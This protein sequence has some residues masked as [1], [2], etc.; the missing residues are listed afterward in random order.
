MDSFVHTRFNAEDRSYLSSLKKEIHILSVSAGFAGSVL[1]E[2]DIIVSE[3][4]TNLTKH[5]INGEI[6]FRILGQN[7]PT[8]I[9]LI[10]IDGGPGFENAEKIFSDGY[11]TMNSLGQGLGAI[12]RLSDFVSV[13]SLPGWGTIVLCRIYLSRQNH[14]H[15]KNIPQ[16]CSIIVPK[17]GE[18]FCGDGLYIKQNGDEW[19]IFAGDG[20]GHGA[21]AHYAVSLAIEYFKKTNPDNLTQFIRG[22]DQALKKTRGLVGTIVT[23]NCEEK[24]LKLLGVGNISSKMFGSNS[25]T[26]LSYNGIIGGNIPN[27]MSE[28]TIS[29]ESN[30]LLIVCSDGIKTNY[31]NQRYPRI[32]KYDLSILAAAIYKDYSRK[33]DDTMIVI[34]RI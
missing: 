5:A 17:P 24:I 10:S 8:G 7:Q 9:E 6:L 28:Q 18:I 20:L 21:E 1:A 15:T 3:L 12:K 34:I 13:Y 25:K 23:L 32:L 16:I 14:L 29:V 2:I 33:T 27:T 31:D 22:M 11:S 19:A 4:A 26:H 30:Q